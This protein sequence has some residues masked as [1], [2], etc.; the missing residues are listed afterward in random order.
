M[1]PN[2]RLIFRHL[3]SQE[4]HHSTA[5]SAP[6]HP[7]CPS[8]PAASRAEHC[9][10]LVLTSCKGHPHSS[11][12]C[13]GWSECQEMRLSSSLIAC[14]LVFCIQSD[15]VIHS[16]LWASALPANPPWKSPRELQIQKLCLVPPLWVPSLFF[17]GSQAVILFFSPQS[18]RL[19]HAESRFFGSLVG[20]LRV[21]EPAHTA[22]KFHQHLQPLQAATDGSRQHNPQNS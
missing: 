11:A 7:Q 6:Q 4:L 21:G 20:E 16:T 3:E 5:P 2:L 9:L 19:F 15:S 13:V 1:L 8:L 18:T 14:K 17:S 12:D 22:P 10:A